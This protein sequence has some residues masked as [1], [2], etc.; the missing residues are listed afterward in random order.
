LK[1]D[2]AEVYK[3]SEETQRGFNEDEKK[4]LELVEV[5]RKNLQDLQDNMEDLQPAIS[6]KLAQILEINR[7]I[8]AAQNGMYR[9]EDLMGIGEERCW[10]IAD[11]LAGQLKKR[12][13][14]VNGVKMAVA[15]IEHMDT[16]MFLSKDI[17]RLKPAASLLQVRSRRSSKDIS[18]S[19]IPG[20][21][22]ME[23]DDM[24]RQEEK[25]EASSWKSVL[26]K[27]P[28]GKVSKMMAKW[29]R[30]SKNI[31]E[32]LKSGSSLLQ[33]GSRRSLKGISLSSIPGL[34]MLE[35][36]DMRR[37][38]EKLEASVGSAS[39]MD[40]GP[41]G[42]V[43]QMI[44]GLIA[45]LKAQANQ[46]VNQHQFC[47]DGLSQNRR[48]T[49]AKQLSIDTMNAASRWSKMA[50]VRLDD[51]LTN[52]AIEQKWLAGIQSTHSKA[53]ASEKTRVNKE[54]AEHKLSTQVITEARV[55]LAQLCDLK[56]E[57]ALV[58]GATHLTQQAHK[59]A[60]LKDLMF[61]QHSHSKV[62]S[63]L[64]GALEQKDSASRFDNCEEAAKILKE[65]SKDLKL[66]DSVTESYIE[67]YA[68]LTAWIMED[69]VEPSFEDQ[70]WELSSVTAARAQRASELATNQKDVR[71]AGKELKLIDDAK[72]ELEHSCSHVETRE[73][74]MARRKDE[75]DALKE[76]LKVLEGESIPSA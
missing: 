37:Q 55:I 31:K 58:A 18:L 16:A 12:R 73:E 20:L 62:R 70:D 1:A 48:D 74:K 49:M 22:M 17:E 51:D 25:L 75:I 44:S 7:T 67:E 57:L 13:Q 3:A 47:Q 8:G 28:F 76:A 5:E 40:A 11:G 35:E 72:K 69:F 36:D 68:D 63:G 26:P 56:G 45:G 34:S 15:L 60:N 71:D 59:A 6:N 53:L 30:E 50:I 2:R 24:R 32:R 64:R 38:E 41:F 39:D 52:V 66:L 42:K 61:L 14:V 23:K 33:V 46:E 21:S 4:I 27:G 29:R 19:S 54:L 9:A 65:T 10:V 43:S